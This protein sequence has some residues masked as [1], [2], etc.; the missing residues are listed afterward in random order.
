MVVAGAGLAQL[1]EWMHYD[2]ISDTATYRVIEPVL[3]VS[4]D[5]RGIGEVEMIW[6]RR[7]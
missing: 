5:G 1:F 6:E 4:D 3:R 2:K 7:F